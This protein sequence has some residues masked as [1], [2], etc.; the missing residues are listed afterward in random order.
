MESEPEQALELL[1]EAVEVGLPFIVGVASVSLTSLRGRVAGA[2]ALA[3]YR[4]L[5]A[6]WRRTGTWP[7]QWVTVRNLLEL[8]A[9]LGSHEAAAVLYGAVEAKAPAPEQGPE[10]ERLVRALSSAE[11]ALGA[12]GIAAAIERGRSMA[13][14]EVIDYA[15]SEVDTLIDGKS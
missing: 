3:G 9:R 5:I 1:E 10:R 14:D 12:Q 11:A 4:E 2:D 6:R 13:R 8:L 15:L 7:Q